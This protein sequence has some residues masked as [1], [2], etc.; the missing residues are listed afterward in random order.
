MRKLKTITTQDHIIH[1][2]ESSELSDD[3]VCGDGIQLQEKITVFYTEGTSNNFTKNNSAD[4]WNFAGEIDSP[5]WVF[6]K[7]N[8]LLGSV[9]T[10]PT[11][12]NIIFI[13]KAK[14]SSSPTPDYLIN[15]DVEEM[16]RESFVELGAHNLTKKKDLDT[17]E[18]EEISLDEEIPDDVI[19]E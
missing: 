13:P 15:V 9:T 16:N 17:Y 10:T 19:I 1:V 8:I 11:L 12:G 5:S 14:V 18:T 7:P 2:V 3:I 4:D 6:G